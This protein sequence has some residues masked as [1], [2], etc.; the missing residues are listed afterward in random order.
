MSRGVERGQVVSSLSDAAARS[1]H[2][3]GGSATLHGVDPGFGGCRKQVHDLSQALGV[4]ESSPACRRVTSTCNQREN[5]CIRFY[6]PR[7]IV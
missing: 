6:M 3:K 7:F 5:T 1:I 4:H 2:D